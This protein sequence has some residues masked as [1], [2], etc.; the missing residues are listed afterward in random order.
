VHSEI[1]DKLPESQ[2]LVN[3][4]VCQD[5]T[6]FNP[7]QLPKTIPA[8]SVKKRL[9][10]YVPYKTLEQIIGTEMT[11]KLKPIISRTS[12][13]LPLYN[14]TSINADVMREATEEELKQDEIGMR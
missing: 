9:A 6:Y 2:V 14:D 4:V 10:S 3:N 12:A 13:A 8:I 11:N 5:R 7:Q 1:V